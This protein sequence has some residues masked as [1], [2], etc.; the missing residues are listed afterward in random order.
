MRKESEEN[1]MG[2]VYEVVPEEDREFLKSMGLKNCWG[3]EALLLSKYT[4]WSADRERDVYLVA[5]GGGYN[6]EMPY[7]YDLWWKGNVI[8]IEAECGG[9][10]NYET[11]VDI[12][13]FINRVPIPEKIWESKDKIMEMIEEAFE[14]NSDWCKKQFLKS[15]TVKIDCEPELKGR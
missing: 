15:I 14:V 5:I 10:G 11:G 3:S 9:K 13:W 12:I 6:G 1:I 2:F 7:F 8:R 4:E